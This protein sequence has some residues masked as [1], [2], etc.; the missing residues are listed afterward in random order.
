MESTAEYSDATRATGERQEM[1]PWQPRVAISI[2]LALLALLPIANWIPGGHSAVFYGV[3]LDGW[4]SGSAIAVGVGIVLAIL[5][6]KMRFLWREDATAGVVEL[7]T[8]RPSIVTIILTAVALALYA[9]IA[10]AVFDGRPLLIDEVVQTFQAQVLAGGELSR[11]AFAYPEFFSS[12]HVIDMNGRVYSQFPMGGPAM[13]LLGVLAH[14]TWLVNPLCAAAAVAAFAVY[15]RT[16]EERPGVALGS[17][18]I[19]AFSPFAAF[20]S[21]SYMNH[22]TSLAWIMVAVAALAKVV[23]SETPRPGM[24]FL[25]GIGFGMA[26]SIRP[27]DAFAF[28]LPAGIWYLARSIHDKRRWTDS[29]MAGAGVALPAVALMWVNLRTTGGPLLFGYEVLWG[30]SHRLGFHAA[31]WGVA[32]T[33]TRGLELINLYFLELQTYFLSTPI[34]S[35]LPAIGA[36]ALS[37][38]LNR[39]DRYLLTSS[40]IVVGLYFAYWHNGFYLGPRFMYPLLP[41]L[42]IW[43]ARF[44]PLLRQRLGEGVVYRSAV[45]AALCAALIAVTVNLPLEA[46]KY[47]NGLLTMRWDADSAAASSGVENALVLVRESWGAQLVA[48]LW[49]LG[50]PRSETE[51]LYRRIDACRLESEVEQLEDR[52]IRGSRAVADLRPLLRDSTRLV[53]SPFSSDTTEQFLP[54]S[55]YSARCLARLNDDRAGFTVFTPLLLAHG[56][57]NIYARD[58]HGRDTLLVRAFPDRKLYLVKAGVRVGDPPRFYPL[59]R[60]SLERAWRDPNR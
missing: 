20:M 17:T 39:F 49:A 45:Y 24:A 27:V 18:L 31:P 57:N 1:Q 59:S 33:P 52:G 28:A 42:A 51:L 30:E 21:G 22:V 5:S 38:R 46:R 48:R 25:S 11:P 56:G 54:G 32:H 3:A 10:L 44:L 34:P 60:D 2:G 47:S 4:I 12:M 8:L 40:A 13:L 55:S 50:V 36:F 41:L 35:L 29:L 58:L 16:T 14:A 23:S 26:A 6:R 43:T 15:A 9:W 19:F 53:G 37:K 7:W